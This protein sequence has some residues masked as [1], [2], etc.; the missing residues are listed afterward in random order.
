MEPLTM[1]LVEPLVVDNFDTSSDGTV[2]AESSD[3]D[4]DALWWDLGE[5]LEGEVHLEP[6]VLAVDTTPVIEHRK[7]K[8]RVRSES[9]AAEKRRK[10]IV[11]DEIKREIRMARNRASAERTRIRR[12]EH[13]KN[14]E[15]E[16]QRIETA[17]YKLLSILRNKYNKSESELKVEGIERDINVPT[18]QPTRRS[19]SKKTD[20]ADVLNKL[21]QNADNLSPEE[22]LEL[23]KEARM[24]RNRA[25]AERTR[26][27]RLEAARQLEV[28][29]SIAKAIR[30][31]YAEM[32]RAEGEDLSRHDIN[33]ADDADLYD[34][35]VSV[36]CSSDDERA[37]PCA[38]REVA[39]K[40]SVCKTGPV[41]GDLQ[42]V[43]Y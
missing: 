6:V 19:R 11:E 25:S 38:G 2:A 24:A 7:D 8:K 40:E 4:I 26:L 43:R 15:T 41:S 27:R 32:L 17:N 31:R 3:S 39:R 1:D 20:A 10:E 34:E 16:A 37:K 33:S 21:E 18:S 12:L 29:V 14:L 5:L 42:T 35:L 23:R 13:I 36:S 30:Q 22:L 28:R 9:Q